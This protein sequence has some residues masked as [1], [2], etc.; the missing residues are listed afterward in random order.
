MQLSMWAQLSASPSIACTSSLLQI[1]CISR[2]KLNEN[3]NYKI[4]I[5]RHCITRNVYTYLSHDQPSHH[6]SVCKCKVGCNRQQKAYSSSYSVYNHRLLQ[7]GHDRMDADQEI[8][9]HYLQ[10]LIQSS[11]WLSNGWYSINI[12][13]LSFSLCHI[14]RAC[15]RQTYYKVRKSTNK[16]QQLQ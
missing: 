9:S 4:N 11:V 1:S 6:G 10:L 14:S 8:L 3:E 7:E 12:E 5:H 16:S 13:S 15:S 2:K